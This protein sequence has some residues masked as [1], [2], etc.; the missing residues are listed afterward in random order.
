M[1]SK[2]KVEEY[3]LVASD[4][5]ILTQKFMVLKKQLYFQNGYIEETIHLMCRCIGVHH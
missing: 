4:F 3:P 2:E 5:F 1:N